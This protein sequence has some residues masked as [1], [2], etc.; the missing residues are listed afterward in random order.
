[1]SVTFVKKLYNCSNCGT[2]DKE[3]LAIKYNSDILSGYPESGRPAE[4]KSNGIYVEQIERDDYGIVTRRVVIE[5]ACPSCNTY[6][7]EADKVDNQENVMNFYPQTE[8]H[9][10]LDGLAKSG[11]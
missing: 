8:A 2:K 4:L 5:K 1:M 6:N 7:L 10:W 11:L 3:L 9:K